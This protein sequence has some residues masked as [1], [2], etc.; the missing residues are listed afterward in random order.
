MTQ[1]L[2]HGKRFFCREWAFAKISH[3]LESRSSSKT[4]GT[5][6]TGGPGSGKT[7]LCCEL[8]WPTN[9][10]SKQSTLSKRL[11]AYHFCQAHDIN[12]LSLASFIN[13]L[14][15]QLTASPLLSGYS[16][17]IKSPE[18]EAALQL[19]EC[20]RN[21]DEAF[22]KGVLFPLLEIDPPSQPCFILVDSVD[23]SILGAVGDKNGG[24]SRSI[25]ELLSNYHHLF[26]RWLLLI[27]SS[28]KQSKTV[29]RMFTGFRKISLDDLR[30]SHVVRDVQ[31]YILC[32]LDQEEALRQHLSRETAEML[33]QLHIK[34]NG[35]FMYLE[36]V[37]D[38]VG[39]NFIMLREIREIPG[40]LNGLYLWLCQRL[41]VRKQ[42]NKVLSILNVILASRKP[43]TEEVLYQCVWTRN[44]NLTWEDYQ[45]RLRLLSKVLIEGKGGTKILFHHSFAEWLLDVKHCTQKYLCNAK[46]GHGM[47][48]MRY[49]VASPHLSSEEII[50]FALHLSKIP[51]TSSLQSHHITL[52]LIHCNLPLADCLMKTSMPKDPQTVKLLV[53]A[54]AKLPT[55]DTVKDSSPKVPDDPLE[56]LLSVGSDINQVDSNQRTL[57]HRASHEGI[58]N[59]VLRLIEKGANLEAIDK[60]G[61]S[62]INL[63]ARQGHARIVE[64][65]LTAGAD[66]DHADNDGWTPLRSSAW[67]G[68]TEVVNVLL[69]H[70]A[71]VDLADADHRTALRAAAWG[72][73]EEIVSRLLAHGACVN[74]VDNEGRTALIAAAYMGHTE[75][76]QQLL[77]HDAEINHEDSD[78]RTA[79]SVAALC[80]PA[81]EGHARVVSLLLE[82]GT[83]VDHRDKDGMTPLLVAAFEGH[84]EVCELLLENEADVDH[85]DNNGRTPLVA[86][87]SMGHPSVIRLL[88]FWGAAVDTIDAEGRTVLSIAA[89]Q[90]DPD[91]V[92]QL[93]DRGLD[94]MHRDNGGWTPLHYAAFE[95][96][97]EACEL[98]LEAGAKITEVDND[99]RIPLILAAQEGH[100]NLVEKL[101]EHTPSMV[102]CR[103]HD[104]KTALRIA[105][106]EGHKET[107]QLLINHGADLNYKDADGRSTLYLLALENRTEL[108]E[109]LLARG[110]DVEARDLEGRTALHVSA[111]QGHTDMVELLLNHGADVNAVDNDYRTALQS[112][113]WQGHVSVVRL[114][115]ERSAVVDH[116]C[117]QGA[118][119]LCIA[120]QEG[121]LEVVKVLLEYGADPSHA[122]QFGRNPIR[123]ASKGGHNHV[124][125]LL[126][127]YVAHLQEVGNANNF[128]G[129]VS[130]TSLTSASTA[131]TKPCSAI[132][133]QPGVVAPSPVE[134]PESTVDKRRSF[135]SNQSS[136]KSSSNL[137]NSTSKST[138]K[139]HSQ[140]QQQGHQQI[141]QESNSNSQSSRAIHNNKTGGST[142]TFTQQL[143]Q[144]TRNRNRISRL[145]SPLSEPHSPVPSP[146]QSPL[147]DIQGQRLSP[148]PVTSPQG[149]GVTGGPF[150]PYSTHVP[151][152]IPPI[153]H[154]STNNSKQ[155]HL[156]RRISGSSGPVDSSHPIPRP[157]EPRVRRNG[158]VTNPNYKGNNIISTPP[159]KNSPV[160]QSTSITVNN[161]SGQIKNKHISQYEESLKANALP[162]KKETHL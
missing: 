88:L 29:T 136:S 3:C 80:V 56:A 108:A 148:V 139:G 90:G 85:T 114:L 95:G 97:T 1:S 128:S 102:D 27:C 126:E 40:T 66:P 69:E 50:D 71:Q 35:C 77:D 84:S 134:S 43:L 120:A 155:S 89:A 14:I 105:T 81:S 117:N 9:I 129:S 25:A 21:P 33:N 82:R 26:P 60:N 137:T 42:F 144:C 131:E 58:D 100:T 138:S 141:S 127:E 113:A 110:A 149:G 154:E 109:F 74:K 32:R 19:A 125:R 70:G 75:I 5:L 30:K 36:K 147:S 116:V 23:Q 157:T 78:G 44:T 160:K 162:F 47:I 132:L 24:I 48:A 135:I 96:H 49:T 130:T 37:L 159:M 118:T 140:P 39:E 63:A 15:S 10:H 38:G 76:V 6:V 59:L 145:L 92:R 93:L 115:V 16:D 161:H 67:A 51:L 53:S 122:D 13:N 22:K 112:A 143:Q 34:S 107:V 121:H 91:T 28:R 64:L 152:V 54:G 57:L 103:A 72:G 7:A 8:V 2:L 142:M 11:L 124:I 87:A 68:H 150:A 123:V 106:L 62:P 153:V 46:E 111:W 17:R 20:E 18:V 31:Q 73:H 83:E 158:I 146:P 41:F 99:G 65:L 133:C 94:E 52:W 55:G 98:L 86:A 151:I 12:S 101:L 156:P 4:C 104:G 119:A 79:L 61:Q 45:K